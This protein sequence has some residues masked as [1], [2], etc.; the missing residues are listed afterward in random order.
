M[1][2]VVTICL[3]IGLSQACESEEGILVNLFTVELLILNIITSF[4]QSCIPTK[5][6]NLNQ[7]TLVFLIA[8]IV[9]YGNVCINLYFFIFIIYLEIRNMTQLW[10]DSINARDMDLWSKFYTKDALVS[11]PGQKGPVNGTGKSFY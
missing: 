5:N 11:A 2:I 9:F 3:T 6:F 8:E 4:L 1:L 7:S 10:T